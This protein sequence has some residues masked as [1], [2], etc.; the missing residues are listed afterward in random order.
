LRSCVPGVVVLLAAL[1]AAAPGSAEPVAPGGVAPGGPVVDL[2]TRLAR[3]GYDPG[4]LNGVMS[5]KTERALLAYRRAAH[6][7]A[8]AGPDA[9]PIAMAQTALRRLGFLTAPADGEIGPQTRDAII[10][11]QAENQLPVDPRVSDRLLADLDRA[12][13]PPGS[14]SAGPPPASPPTANPPAANPSAPA[15]SEPE[16][17]GREPLPA[18]VTPPPI[19]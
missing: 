2:Q 17:T 1:C 3:A 14:S 4:P 16:A 9:G 12:G 19:H 18:G 15:P 13:A 11:F 6:Q 5:A 10:R 8:V 7:P